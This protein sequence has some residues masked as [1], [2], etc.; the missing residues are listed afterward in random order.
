MIKLFF[1]NLLL[2]SILFNSVSSFAA[3]INPCAVFV[4]QASNTV[5]DVFFF[6]RI[7]DRLSEKGYFLVE[8]KEEAAFT[9]QADVTALNSKKQILQALKNIEVCPNAAVMDDD[10]QEVAPY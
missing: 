5:S 9:I 1:M 3:D 4:N 7:A 6:G 2:M 8:N 10:F